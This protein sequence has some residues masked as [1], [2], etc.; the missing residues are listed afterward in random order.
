[1]LVNNQNPKNKKKPDHQQQA[2][3][4]KFLRENVV[5]KETRMLNRNA[6]RSCS[7]IEQCTIHI[8]ALTSVS[9]KMNVTSRLVLS[10]HTAL[11]AIFK[12]SFGDFYTYE[13]EEA[14]FQE[15]RKKL[16]NMEQYITDYQ[17]DKKYFVTQIEKTTKSFI[18]FD[19]LNV[20]VQRFDHPKIILTQKKVLEAQL[21]NLPNFD[22]NI[23][24]F[25]EYSVRHEERLSIKLKMLSDMRKVIK[26]GERWLELEKAKEKPKTLSWVAGWVDQNHQR[27]LEIAVKEVSQEFNMADMEW[28]DFLKF[29]EKRINV[30]TQQ[31]SQLKQYSDTQAAMQCKKTFK[32]PGSGTQ[33]E[34]ALKGIL[35]YTYENSF[36]LHTEILSILNQNSVSL[37]VKNKEINRLVEKRKNKVV[38]QLVALVTLD[39]SFAPLLENFMLSNFRGVVKVLQSMLVFLSQENIRRVD[40]FNVKLEEFFG[41]NPTIIDKTLRSFKAYK[42]SSDLMLD[43][44]RIDIFEETLERASKDLLHKKTSGALLFQSA[45]TETFPDVPQDVFQA[46]LDQGNLQLS[47]HAQS[48]FRE[49]KSLLETIECLFDS[50]QTV[51]F[52]EI[53]KLIDILRNDNDQTS[54]TENHVM[55]RLPD[56][57]QGISL[58]KQ[59]LVALPHECKHDGV[60]IEDPNKRAEMKRGFF[61]AGLRPGFIK[62]A[63]SPTIKVV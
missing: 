43:A 59:V 13:T 57:W 63:N 61:E 25:L 32:F 55:Y 11:E 29:I 1:M 5:T 33:C 3:I 46:F 52:S 49:D 20:D 35:S 40:I 54:S 2:M 44:E 53:R 21:K 24:I 23:D 37:S 30:S 51:R 60:A 10:L 16:N 34:H 42:L 17:N 9:K 19:A 7:I 50:K 18:E 62:V 38:K 58:K 15:A 45:R 27:L 8:N 36:N 39:P 26:E 47:E 48:C 12:K 4:K 6:E 56:I 14:T 41:K 22:N 31:M 28:E